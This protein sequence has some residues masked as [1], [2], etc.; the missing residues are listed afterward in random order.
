MAYRKPQ[1]LGHVRRPVACAAPD[2]QHRPSES[3]ERPLVAGCPLQA[4]NSHLRFGT[5]AQQTAAAR[6]ALRFAAQ[7]AALDMMVQQR[8][9]RWTGSILAELVPDGA[10]G[11]RLRLS[12][13]QDALLTGALGKFQRGKRVS[14]A[15]NFVGS[16]RGA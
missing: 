15:E 2:K 10:A 13:G 7:P 1:L 4:W 12:E 8:T 3:G 9:A 6:C 11:G 14:I 16:H 5:E